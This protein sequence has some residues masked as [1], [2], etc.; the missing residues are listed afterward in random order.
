MWSFACL[1]PVVSVPVVAALRKLH[2]SRRRPSPQRRSPR[3]NERLEFPFL[4]PK[5]RCKEI[6]RAPCRQVGACRQRCGC[7]RVKSGEWRRRLRPDFSELVQYDPDMLPART[8][9]RSKTNLV[10]RWLLARHRLAGAVRARDYARSCATCCSIAG[11]EMPRRSSSALAAGRGSFCRRVDWT[12]A[13]P[14][15]E[16]RSPAACAAGSGRAPEHRRAFPPSGDWSKLDPIVRRCV[17]STPCRR[18]TRG[19]ANTDRVSVG[20]ATGAANATQCCRAIQTNG[21]LCGGRPCSGTG[22]A[23]V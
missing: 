5:A 15:T 19:P 22:V 13:I 1:H 6:E 12:G 17:F 7:S 4:R 20:Q 14:S 9:V 3:V 8:R 2:R 10:R 11:R 18:G 23:A 16:Y 21:D